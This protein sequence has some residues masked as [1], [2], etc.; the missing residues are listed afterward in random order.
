MFKKIHNVEICL[1]PEALKSIW[2]EAPNG[3]LLSMAKNTECSNSQTDPIIS[4]VTS[5]N[6]VAR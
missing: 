5:T 1:E 6:N 4:K 3:S 2:W